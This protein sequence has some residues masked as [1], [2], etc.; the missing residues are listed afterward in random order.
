MNGPTP[1]CG[2]WPSAR[3]SGCC[4]GSGCARCWNATR[5][6]ATMPV[7]RG[8][9]GGWS[10]TPASSNRR[11]GVPR[12]GGAPGQAARDHAARRGRAGGGSRGS[13]GRRRRLVG[14]ACDSVGAAPHSGSPPNSPGR[15]AA[16][17]RDVHADRRAQHSGDPEQPD[18]RAV[19]DPAPRPGRPGGQRAAGV[20]RGAVH[21]PV[22]GPGSRFRTNLFI[23]DVCANKPGGTYRWAVSGRTLRFAAVSDPYAARVAFFTSGPWRAIS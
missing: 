17:G 2:G 22:P 5:R 12:N 6:W 18:G 9:R 7:E 14:A 4:A 23:Q 21:L 15:P 13:R 20:H 11:R 16:P 1:G 10:A 3:R 8:I 19:D